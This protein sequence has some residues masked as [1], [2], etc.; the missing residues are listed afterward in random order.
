M[1]CNQHAAFTVG[2]AV[3]TDNLSM[4]WPGQMGV[5]PT[6]IFYGPAFAGDGKGTTIGSWQMS[7]ISTL[8]PFDMFYQPPGNA[9]NTIKWT[10]FQSYTIR[11]VANEQANTPETF[12]MTNVD[13]SSND[14]PNIAG[15]T[16][17]P[18]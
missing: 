8:N 9:I 14:L 4:V 15:Q 3:T 1:L 12:W 13:F 11:Y 18:A 5:T 7:R 6:P 2:D 10:N 17:G 16:G